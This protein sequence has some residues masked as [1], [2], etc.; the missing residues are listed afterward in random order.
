MFTAVINGCGKD[1]PDRNYVA[2]VDNAHLRED[3]INAELDTF[4]IQPGRRN[5][6]IR[7]W[8]ETEIY[9]QEAIKEEI[10]EDR[11]FQRIL[12]KTRREL[13]KS[14][15]IKKIFSET[16]FDYNQQDLEDFYLANK[17]E[18]KVFNETYLYNVIVFN[19]EDKAVLFRNTLVESDWNKTSNVFRG[20]PS[21]VREHIGILQSDY[22]IQP[23][24]L[25]LMMQ[26][27]MPDEVSIIL[28]MEPSDF[29]IVQLIKKYQENEIP[30]F[31]VVKNQVEEKFLM[32][33]RREFLRNYQKEIYSNYKI[34]IK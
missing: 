32:Q 19:E 31:E 8:I 20:D 12:N 1:E 3:D 15:L 5:E 25:Y 29:T 17:E 14:F 13:A 34:E 7:N 27:L 9:Y 24:N 6:Y 22:Q 28:N 2:R 10:T 33:K 21:I 11:E 23:Y 16:E 18:F 4:N 30:E 26:N